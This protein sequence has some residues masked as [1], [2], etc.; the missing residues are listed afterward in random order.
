ME[1][2]R[3]VHKTWGGVYKTLSSGYAV[4]DGVVKR[5]SWGGCT[6]PSCDNMSRKYKRLVEKSN[7]FRRMRGD[8][9]EPEGLNMFIIYYTIVSNCQLN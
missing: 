3:E 2:G 7:V 1:K 4:V 9:R 5:S 6:G 8:K